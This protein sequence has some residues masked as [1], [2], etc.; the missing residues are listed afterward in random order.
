MRQEAL[1]HRIVAL[2]ATP[3]S[4]QAEGR[5]VPLWLTPDA[6]ELTDAEDPDARLTC[7]LCG[8]LLNPRR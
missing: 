2:P 1:R 3:P 4:L 8:D 5:V 7:S 6:E